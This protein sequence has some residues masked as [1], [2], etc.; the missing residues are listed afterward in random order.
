MLCALTVRQLKPGSFDEF[1]EAFRPPEG[2]MAP[3]G[4]KRFSAIRDGD[5]V[6]TFGFFDGTMDELEASQEG[7]GYA[8]RRQRAEEHVEEVVV[9]G[10]FEV[11]MDLDVDKAPAA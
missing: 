11:V 2:V 3:D 9:N 10:V 1:M 8:E 5:R 7:H 4:W 6:I